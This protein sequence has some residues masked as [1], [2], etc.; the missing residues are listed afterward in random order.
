MKS[1]ETLG[2]R[3]TAYAHSTLSKKFLLFLLV[4]LLSFSSEREKEDVKLAQTYFYRG[5]I[6]FTQGNYKDA[7]A[8][9][10]RSYLA[11]VE[12]YYGELSYLYIGMS[13]AWLSYRTGEKAGVASAIAYLN[14]YPYHYKKATY[15]SLQKEFIAQAYFLLGFYD[16]AK[17][18]FLALYRE[19][20]RVDYLISF[21]HADALSQGSN[22]MLLDQIDPNLLVEKRY[23]YYL[24]RGFYAFNQGDYKQAL[25]DLQEARSLNRYLEDDPEFLYRY[26]VGSFMIKDWRNATFYFEQL[27]RK[28]MYR[29]YQDSVNYYLTLVYLMSKNYADAKKRLEN[30]SNLNNI[31]NRL[32]LSQLWL[33]PDFLEKNKQE[34]KDYKQTL[35]K[36]AWIDL[37]SLYSTPAVLGLYNYILKERKT[38]DGDLLKLKKLSI[39]KEIVFQDI[40]IDTLPML[41]TVRKS[42]QD[43][44]A[45]KEAQFLIDLYKVNPENF[46][47]LFGYEKIARAVVSSG[48]TSMKD[49]VLKTEEPIRSF[50]YGQIL[51]LEGYKEGLNL[52]EKA[53]KDLTAE[54]RHEASLIL[55]IYKKDAKML[56]ALLNEKLPDRFNS[57]IEIALLEVGDFYYLRGEYAKAK[58]YY[59]KYLETAQEGDLYWFIAYRLAKAGELTKDQETID[60]VVKKAKGKDNIISRVIIALWG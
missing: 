29:T 33:F 43:L 23:L 32:L 34:Y 27:D 21:L 4:F 9:F 35:N 3:R 14:M 51:L 16:R 15:L 24:V 40:R 1:S 6:E 52:I 39:P 25:A 44:D 48:E 18:L 10:G 56:E 57:Y 20:G 55:G 11:D 42:F 59:R 53:Q 38:G 54:D 31:K 5:Y 13:Y 8:E 37:N 28:D 41:E 17:D 26:A 60:W 47:L 19:T 58:T 2:T 30:M 45:Y 36:I 46:S 12:G 50:L 49:V 7:I 22:Y